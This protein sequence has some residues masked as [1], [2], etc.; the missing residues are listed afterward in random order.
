MGDL[1][2]GRPIGRNPS[3]DRPRPTILHQSAA[4]KRAIGSHQQKLAQRS[5]FRQRHA[6]GA[7][8]NHTRCC[9]FGMT[10][11][12]WRCCKRCASCGCHNGDAEQSCNPSEHRFF[13]SVGVKIIGASRTPQETRR[14][15][16]HVT[17]PGAEETPGFT[18]TGVKKLPIRV[19]V[20][21]ALGKTGT[22]G[23][24]EAS[25]TMTAK[26]R[27]CRRNGG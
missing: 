23:S 15:N 22:A 21:G 18:T 9:G 19:W 17:L 16:G 13:L 8:P 6:V 27:P 2:A 11:R 7:Q 1:D 10:G 4:G 20:A 14:S 24:L 3:G 5:P 26:D 25:R 12:H